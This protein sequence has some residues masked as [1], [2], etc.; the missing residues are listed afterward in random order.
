MMGVNVLVE[1]N[2]TS[3]I[4]PDTIVVDGA[5][6]INGGGRTLMPGLIEGH[7]H[8]QMN[9]NSLTD[10][11]N[12][13]SWEELATRPAAKARGAGNGSV[14]RGQTGRDRKRSLC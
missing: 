13:R 9:G 10:I 11:E 5:Q 7:G 8:L 4:D 2:L 1:D 12:N 14:F 6:V 3:A